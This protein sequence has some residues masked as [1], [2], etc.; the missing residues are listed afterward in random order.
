MANNNLG[1]SVTAGLDKPKSVTQINNDILKIEGQLKKLKLQAKIDGKSNAEIQKQISA[2]NKQKRNLYVDLKLRQKDLKKQYK[3]AVAE[4]NQKPIDIAVNTK[5]AE[6]QLSGL[7]NSVKT[8]RSET[9]TLGNTLTKMLNNMGL[10]V[11]AQTALNTIRKAA[12]EATDAVKE[13]DSYAKNLKIITNKDD[14]SDLI[15]DYAKKSLDMKV[16]VSE[17]EQAS[18]VILRAG[19]NIKESAEY[20]ETAIKLAKTGFIE[21]DESASNLIVVANAFDI[22]ADKL[23]NLTDVLLSLDSMTNTTAGNL[24]SA[25]SR[26]AQNAKLAGMSYTELATTIAKLRDTTGKSESE[27]SNSLN[28]IFNRTYR[29]KLGKYILE[30]EDGSTEDITQ[31]LSDAEKMLNAVNISI[32]NSKGEFKDFTEIISTISPKFKELD[33]VTKNSIANVLGGSYHKNVVLN[34]LEDWGDIQSLVE[35]VQ[36][37]IGVTDAKYNAYLNSIEGKT[38]A[39]STAM[40]DLWNNLIP[41]GFVGDITDATT[42]IVQFTDEYQILQTAI[43]SAT[44]YALAK[45]I[46]SA[47]NGFAGMITDIKN[48][49]YA[50][51]MASSSSAMT[52]EQ[53][54][55]F[56]VVLSGLSDK[57]L[58]LVLSNSNLSESE[59]IKALTIDGT[60]EAEARQRLATLGLTQA[61]QQAT[62]STFSLNGSMKML[63]STICANPVMVLT[64]AFTALVSIYQKVQREQEEARKTAI[65][66]ADKYKEQATALKNLRQEYINIVDSESDVSKKTEELN[67]WKKTLIETYGFEKEALENV[68]LEREKGL[69]LLDDEITKNHINSAETWLTENNKAYEDAKKK[70]TSRN[71]STEN[72]V[73]ARANVVDNVT[74]DTIKE[75]SDNFD[76]ILKQLSISN[77]TH[78]NPLAQIRINGSNTLQQ[79]ENLNKILNDITSIKVTKG[80]NDAEEDLYNSLLAKQ[81]A[82]KKVVT[83]D[84]KDIYETGNK[85]TNSI[86]LFNFE[87][88][89]GINF[90]NVTQD[91]YKE[92]RDKF[93]ESLGLGDK[94][95][96]TAFAL[97]I[98]QTL[99]DMMPDFEKVYRGIED[100]TSDIAQETNDAI[101]NSAETASKSL[102][103][104]QKAYDELS[105]SASNYTKNQKSIT[106]ALEE[107]EKYGQLSAS[108]IQELTEAGYAQALVIDNETGAVTLNKQAYEQLNKEKKQAIILGAEQQKTDLEQKYK[109]E[110]TAISD[111]TLEMK[112]ANEERRKA[113]LL[114]LSQHGQ[115]MAEYLDMIDK[116]NSSTASINAPTFE[117][118]KKEEKPDSVLKF[119]EELAKRQ[120]EIAI[121]KRKEDASYYNWLES[122]AKKAYEG[123]EGYE[124]DLWKYEEQVYNWRKEHEQELFDQK[125]DNYEKLADK[126]LDDKV[127]VPEES[128]KLADFNKKMQDDYGLGNVDLTK[129]PKVNMPDGSIAT[130]YSDYEFLWQGDEENGKYVAVHYTPILPDGTILDDESLRKYIFGTLEGANDIL[131]A[132]TKGIVL[133]VDTDIDI[134]EL[135]I[136]SLEDGKPTENIQNIMKAC[137]DW[138]IALHEVQAEWLTLSEAAEKAGTTVTNKFDYAREQIVSAISET[139]NRINELKASGKQDVEDEIKSLEEDIEKF[140][141]KLDKIDKDELDY[142][143]GNYEKLADKALED[144]PET[145]TATK[146]EDEKKSETDNAKADT[147]DNGIITGKMERMTFD[148]ENSDIDDE[149]TDKAGTAIENFFRNLEQSLGL[150]SGSLT[151]ENAYQMYSNSP[152]MNFD[153]YGA[154]KDRSGLANKEYVSNVNNNNNAANVTIGDININNP[155]GN[156]NDL[157]KELMMNLPNAFQKQ[158]YTNLK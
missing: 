42:K 6:K 80:L 120:H 9:V 2:L 110:Q 134:S 86:K 102:D 77:P 33:D 99:L 74:K 63:W 104:L 67:E 58:K 35:N 34:L 118:G 8:T 155:V 152:M 116:I 55:S 64:I 44:F 96:S 75:Y 124:D 78:D 144:K 32:R 108:T 132:D 45:G 91:T 153:P 146:T 25:L 61:N 43:K 17:Y 89:N 130:V 37:N 117:D 157:A 62:A 111:L 41:N 29:V 4:I 105:K 135:D 101:S 97:E 113:I 133:K 128:I 85:Y 48:V 39:L 53:F 36:D 79:Y 126:I 22:S 158:I 123:L 65:E 148:S 156:S 106:S 127:E 150:K 30:N 27:I 71:N 23:K 103:D 54:A 14:V 13:Y 50:M 68:N 141:E 18:E 149:V 87:T 151:L 121:G 28:Q 142:N 52:K 125:I 69:G 11:S 21:A 94:K 49:S 10:V 129:R 92:F 26:S 95:D 81:K 115:N 7:N 90:N 66:M 122:A 112:Y 109:D 98:E 119:E 51:N 93:L 114:E 16:D 143:V 46:V 19:K 57:Q 107:Q 76:E 1:L 72:A 131:K 70:L 40:K 56:S 82:Y 136:K 24:S 73:I 137:N 147:E 88:D 3:Q 59:M 47:K 5:N 12:Q 15:A 154:M 31:E 145:E 83:D 38:S 140:Q 60:T 139:Q 100:N 138:G 20:T 84:I